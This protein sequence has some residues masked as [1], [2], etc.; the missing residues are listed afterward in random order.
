MD[1]ASTGVKVVRAKKS[2]EG[3]SLLGIEVLPPI[4]LKELAEED[5]SGNKLPLSKNF[6]PY[7]AALSVSG[8]SAIVR[9]LSLP[10]QPDQNELAEKQIRDHLSLE[11]KFRLG[12]IRTNP[13]Q[14]KSETR[15]LAVALSEEEATHIEKLVASGSPAPLAL[16]ISGLSALSGFTISMGPTIED[17]A[18]GFVEA[19]SKVTIIA[20]FNR[21]VPALIRKFDFGGEA[22]I[23]KV[24]QQMGVDHNVAEGIISD[25]S[26]DI[27]QSVKDILD[28][29]LRQLTISRDFVERRENCRIS[30][31]YMSGGM[32]L[33]SYW[34]DELQRSTGMGVEAWNPFSGFQVAPDA[35]PR[36]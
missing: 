19:G 23:R 24:Q 2:K 15:V 34:R 30:K 35:I 3:L 27:S 28:P 17:Q 21:G 11:G 13:P 31:L 12:Y 14:K 9:H 26:F 22:L 18:V 7:Y 4:Q 32:S 36:T 6:R 10:G 16:E 33:S 8:E 5:G 1:I 20:L 29:F 25:G